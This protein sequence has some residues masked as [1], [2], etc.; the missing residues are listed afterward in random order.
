MKRGLILYFALFLSAGLCS[1]AITFTGDVSVDFDQNSIVVTDQ[2][3]ENDVCKPYGITS[4]GW[5]FY[6]VYFHY[7]RTEDRLYIGLDFNGRICGDADGDGDPSN[8]GSTLFG[9]GGTDVA[10]LGTDECVCIYFDTNRRGGY[11]VICGIPRYGAYSDYRVCY[12]QSDPNG[13]PSNSFGNQISTAS[14][15]YAYSYCPDASH[16]DFECTI[17]N[18]SQLPY[19][20]FNPATD[21]V[22][23]RMG[24]YAGSW[25][26]DGIG[27]DIISNSKRTVTFYAETTIPHNIPRD[28][29]VMQGIPVM[30]SNGNPEHLFM[31]SFGNPPSW[32][33]P[34][35]RVSRWNHELQTYERYSEQNWP[36]AVG[37]DPPDQD[38]GKG[39]WVVQD[40]V[41]N[42][43]I[44]ITGTAFEPG[45]TVY[46]NLSKPLSGGRRGIV[47]LANPFHVPVQWC[48]AYLRYQ[49]FSGTPIPLINAVC[50]E[51]I[52]GYAATWDPYGME[53]IP[54]GYCAYIE[55]WQA[56]WATQFNENNDY[57]LC[58]D[59]PSSDA[60][61]ENRILGG[62][63]P[64]ELDNYGEWYFNIGVAC[65]TID[66]T[67]F[68]NV[69]GIIDS[70]SDGYDN[71]DFREYNPMSTQGY[72]QLLFPHQDWGANPDNYSY[73]IRHGPFEGEKTWEFN[74]RSGGY[75]GNITV[76]WDGVFHAYPEYELSLLDEQGNVVVA[77]MYS[78]ETMTLSISSGE[79]KVYR[80]RVV[81]LGQGVEGRNLTAPEDYSLSAAYPNP[82]NNETLVKLSLPAAS[83]VK[84]ALYDVTGR[85]A[86]T[87]V[88]R[89]FA[90]GT[91]SVSVDASGLASGMYFLKADA[92]GKT[93]AVQKLALLK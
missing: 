69:I 46:Q 59:F 54:N 44:T 73:D 55:P 19:F 27:R 5:D 93:F 57:V 85:L 38:P 10:N 4:T 67:D 89:Y 40:Y 21:E 14:A 13:N 43:T 11:D 76:M 65:E 31:A 45:W 64:E 17:D 82:F 77:D 8:T 80:I 79:I 86:R 60:L 30:V 32:G 53:Y 26:D 84:L 52:C 62:G 63:P 42:C 33:H 2:N 24:A 75:S 87:V 16:P 29:Y 25:T 72:V 37:G 49:P 51:L 6:S 78:E 23:F 28:L 20:N 7:D 50:Q 47:Q 61:S 22:V 56:Y 81:G 1:A 18:F 58:F 36:I 83:D 3:G 74:L 66:Q 88:E 48:D 70:A 92:A 71:L 15:S 41:D 9:Y 68:G 90:E 12:S 34:Y 35:C 39:F 91:H